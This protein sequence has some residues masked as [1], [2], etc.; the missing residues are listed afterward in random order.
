MIL[1][2]HLASG[3]FSHGIVNYRYVDSI[4]ALSRIN[5]PILLEGLKR[6]TAHAVIVGYLWIH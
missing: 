4:Q 2:L 5:K 1:S 6:L 3:I